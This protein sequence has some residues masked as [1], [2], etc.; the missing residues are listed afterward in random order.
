VDGIAQ[1]QPISIGTA[2]D[3]KWAV[4]S[5]LSGGEQ[6]IVNGLQKVKPDQPVT[7]VPQAE[8]N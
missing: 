7:A 3:G 1:V 5:G 6:V 4:E 8:E 2:V